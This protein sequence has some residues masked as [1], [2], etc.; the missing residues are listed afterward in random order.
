[1][2]RSEMVLE[3]ASN[4]VCNYPKIPFDEAQDIAGK[5][6]YVAEQNDMLPPAIYIKSF[7]KY[8]NVWEPE[9]D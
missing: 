5:M 3:M 6:L 4:L 1:M 8:D 7:D 9:N 2:K